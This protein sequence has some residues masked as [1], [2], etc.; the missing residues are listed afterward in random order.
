MKQ[1]LINKYT[2]ATTPKMGAALPASLLSG[3]VLN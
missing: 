2:E 3:T 1:S